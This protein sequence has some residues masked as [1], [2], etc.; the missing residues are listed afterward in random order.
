[1]F[2]ISLFDCSIHFFY[3]HTLKIRKCGS[4]RHNKHVFLCDTRNLGML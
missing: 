4:L 3:T 1:M 2:S